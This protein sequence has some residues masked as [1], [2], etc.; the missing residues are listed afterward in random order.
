MSKKLNFKSQD[1][2]T[3]RSILKANSPR[4]T[5]HSISSTKA[6][7]GHGIFKRAS[8]NESKSVTDVLSTSIRKT[9]S[10]SVTQTVDDFKGIVSV[11]G[12]VAYIYRRYYCSKFK[13][14]LQI[15]AK[16]PD[17]QTKKVQFLESPRKSDD[18]NE[19]HF[20]YRLDCDNAGDDSE[21]HN[22]L[23]SS[24]GQIID[25]KTDNILDL[26]SAIPT[27]VSPREDL[28]PNDINSLSK[29]TSIERTFV[30]VLLILFFIMI[31]KHFRFDWV[32]PSTIK[33]PLTGSE[34]ITLM[35]TNVK[36]IWKNLVSLQ[37]HFW[38]STK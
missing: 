6:I 5:R 13:S 4:Q 2:E 31:L 32:L 18:N 38:Y 1:N 24:M 8:L 34:I 35:G 20:Q 3:S 11:D 16:S 10:D 19:N 7:S 33:T 23:K 36:R 21:F 17:K 26:L 14:K 28:R 25:D 29:M 37:R 12:V 22:L 30:M 15:R 27:E 9:I